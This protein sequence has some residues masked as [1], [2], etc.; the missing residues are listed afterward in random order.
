MDCLG[1]PE[2]LMVAGSVGN[3]PHDPSDK[4]ALSTFTKEEGRMACWAGTDQCES[5]W[6]FSKV[7]EML[8]I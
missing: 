1:P 8:K 4:A 3:A 6:E 2:N 7:D 5:I